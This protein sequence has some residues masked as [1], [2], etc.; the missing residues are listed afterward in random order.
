MKWSETKTST[1]LS[2]VILLLSFGF[3]LLADF[4]ANDKPIL[5]RDSSG[6]WLIF[7]KEEA[8]NTVFLRAP[9]RHKTNLDL[10]NNLA[11]PF[12][13][14][15]H[16][17]GTDHLG[18]D[19]LG[20]LIHGSRVSFGFSIITILLALI[21]G[22]LVG[23]ISGFL[24]DSGLRLYVGQLLLI[25]FCILAVSYGLLI[26]LSFWSLTIILL[27]FSGI[28]YLLWSRL[29]Y[30]IV[31]IPLDFIML[32]MI[33]IFS[34]IPTYF[35]VLAILSLFNPGWILFVTIISLVSWFGIARLVRAEM[36]KIRNAPYIEVARTIGLSSWRIF[37][38]H[39]LPNAVGPLPYAITFGIGSIMILESTFSYFGIGL[40][41]EH[42]SWGTILSG[43][44][45]NSS[46]WWIAFFPGL[47]IF[48]NILSLH[49]V[50][51]WLDRA[52][53]PQKTW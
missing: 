40:A 18:R 14:K 35:L 29:R 26:H 7:A 5:Q 45:E 8:S 49:N 17:L 33:E 53:N 44:K 1:R 10:A 51:R 16:V 46:A 20:G 13:A 31:T 24:G 11:A 34:S 28:F 43:F 48:I 39:A 37:F 27:F 22:T 21:T 38:K 30:F 36:I 47:L 12:K 23:G 42:T 52:F 2:I 25:A 9:V 32:K 19:I 15:G 50:G 3:A 41:S 6:S 4:L